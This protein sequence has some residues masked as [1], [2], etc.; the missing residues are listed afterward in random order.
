MKR[1]TNHQEKVWKCPRCS[2]FWPESTISV[3]PVSK[4]LYCRICQSE[5]LRQCEE[6]V[7]E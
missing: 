2:Q 6:V 7:I 3:R 5:D 1:D 4:T